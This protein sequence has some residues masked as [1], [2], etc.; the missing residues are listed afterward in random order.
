MLVAEV[1]SSATSAIPVVLAADTDANFDAI[2]V[3]TTG[4]V[5]VITAQ[6]QTVTF[7]TVPVGMLPIRVRQIKS[8]VNGTTAANLVGLSW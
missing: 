7:K 1:V 6:N 5:V 4:D 3:G 2:Y 8:T